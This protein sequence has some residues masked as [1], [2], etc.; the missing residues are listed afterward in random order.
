MNFLFKSVLLRIITYHWI[1]THVNY[2]YN[3]CDEMKNDSSYH[4]PSVK[5]QDRPIF[6]ISDYPNVLFLVARESKDVFGD[7][8]LSSPE[9]TVHRQRG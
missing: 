2:D 9:T 6:M 8:F 7:I 1:S 5:L 4:A 3:E